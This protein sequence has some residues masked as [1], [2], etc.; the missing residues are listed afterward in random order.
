LEAELYE[1]GSDL[2]KLQE[3]TSTKT[4]VEIELEN[5][6]LLWEDLSNQIAG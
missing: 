2:A 3:I 5:A 1:H 6:M 4:A